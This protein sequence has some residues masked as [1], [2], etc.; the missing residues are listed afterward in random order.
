MQVAK[1]I[2]PMHN[3]R[4]AVDRDDAY[5]IL[6][7]M[8]LKS[9]SK[10]IAC[11]VILD[12]IRCDLNYMGGTLVSASAYTNN[13]DYGVD[14]TALAKRIVKNEIGLPYDLIIRGWFVL[15]IEV[16]CQGADYY[17]D[18]D[19]TQACLR[20]ALVPDHPHHDKLEF[21]MHEYINRSPWLTMRPL[22]HDLSTY[23]W[24]V[25]GC[26]TEFPRGIHTDS[27][28]SM[29]SRINAI[30]T[31]SRYDTAG[32]LYKIGTNTDTEDGFVK[33]AIY[34]EERR[35]T[36]VYTVVGYEHR[37][38][39]SGRVSPWA[40]LRDAAGAQI[41]CNLINR[42]NAMRCIGLHG[43]KVWVDKVGFAAP[44]V[45][46]LYKS[47]DFDG[48]PVVHDIT[49]CPVCGTALKIEGE[50]NPWC[51]NAQC[52]GRKLGLIKY[53]LS[54]PMMSV[55]VPHQGYYE[56]IMGAIDALKQPVAMGIFNITASKLPL[57]MHERIQ[58]NRVMPLYKAFMLLDI[59]N[60]TMVMA[61]NLT[62]HRASLKNVFMSLV[63]VRSTREHDA[64]AQWWAI[65][66]NRELV[67]HLDS[68]LSYG[69]PAAHK[70]S[71][72]VCISGL[73]EETRPSLIAKLQRMG[74]GYHVSP[75]ANTDYILV[76]RRVGDIWESVKRNNIKVI[77]DIKELPELTKE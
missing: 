43:D 64:L 4:Q 29:L 44:Y 5:A 27:L 68:M 28:K 12:G 26:R 67:N 48:D 54:K 72:H 73:L 58:V 47:C 77:R 15:P 18:P 3:Y 57:D 42:L 19:N 37:V 65:S 9:N 63:N 51:P 17:T 69:Y 59:P 46:G 10:T 33:N 39:K 34:V 45:R 25:G 22:M 1:H 71:K 36:E 7:E 11:E 74:Y 16:L 70:F 30:R 23:F 20:E 38:M 32:Y 55:L 24:I 50:A 56:T 62:Q 75:N 31:S 13:P 53:I 61:K 35:I 66:E 52:S 14:V 60:I 2:L 40:I 76:G 6:K 21:M 49:K 41:S 8:F